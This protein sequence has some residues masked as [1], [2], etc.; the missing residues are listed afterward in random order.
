MTELVG[1]KTGISG[2]VARV[3]VSFFFFRKKKDKCVIYVMIPP[4]T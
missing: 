1:R 2:A 3:L 4:R